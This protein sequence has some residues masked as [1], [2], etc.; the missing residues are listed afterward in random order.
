MPL[1]G[2]LVPLLFSLAFLLPA[3]WLYRRD[4]RL[5]SLAPA[6]TALVLAGTTVAIYVADVNKV[7]A[8][9]DLDLLLTELAKRDLYT[10][11]ELRDER[12]TLFLFSSASQA[13][14]RGRD[15]APERVGA[16]DSVLQAMAAWT[17]RASNLPQWHAGTDWDRSVFFL[18]HAGAV[19]GHYQLATNDERYA[20]YFRRIGDYLGQRMMRGHYKHLGSSG[21]ENLLRP[22]D[23]AAAIYVLTLFDAYYG[24]QYA[25][26]TRQEWTAYIKKELY[27]AESRLP[28]AAFNETNRCSIEP[29]AAATGLYISYRAAAAPAEV[30]DDIPYRE[31]LHY[32]K[33]FSGSPFGLSIRPNMRS[34]VEARLCNAG[35]SPL[36]CGHFEDAIGLWAAAE[37]GGGYTYFRLFSGPVFE[38]WFGGIPDFA[39]LRPARRVRALTVVA[40]RCI[41]EGT[42]RGA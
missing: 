5:L 36:D 22:A 4:R 34:G 1:T 18:A 33:R 24:E 30:R 17:I 35:L 25:G 20:P 28:C 23:N 42:Q 19:L 10:T 15:Y 32:F 7:Q 39:A 38:R 29:S 21:D 3:W 14:Y 40:L 26:R 16:I 37:Y 8:R 2:L 31:W 11:T 6:F 13:L 27:Y 41:G 12:E 9:Y